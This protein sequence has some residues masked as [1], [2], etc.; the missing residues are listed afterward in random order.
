MKRGASLFGKEFPPEII[1]EKGGAFGDRFLTFFSL[2]FFSSMTTTLAQMR[3]NINLDFCGVL[4]PIWHHHYHL[5]D[6]Q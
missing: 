5:P 2:T 3:F 4:Q 1:K 6:L